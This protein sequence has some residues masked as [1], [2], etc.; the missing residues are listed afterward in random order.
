[1]VK[2]AIL[3]YDKNGREK[4]MAELSRNPGPFVHNDLYVTVSDLNGTSLAH[5][6]P[7]MMGKNLIDLRDADGKYIQRE[8]IE[9]SQKQATGWQDYKF[10]NPVT[11]KIEAKHTFWEKHDNLLFA[12]G[13][14][15]PE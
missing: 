13:A 12:C 4:A 2:K 10:Y 1:M 6:N 14:Y 8:R 5:I 7:K 9:A 3:F 11:K 15:K